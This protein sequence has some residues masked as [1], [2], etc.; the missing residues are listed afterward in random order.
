MKQ[1][2]ISLSDMYAGIAVRGIKNFG[3]LF[4]AKQIIFD[5]KLPYF[6][7]HLLD[8]KFVMMHE[9]FIDDESRIFRARFVRS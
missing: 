8:E 7:D 2:D 1:D 6:V 3:N 5:T 9:S 4:D